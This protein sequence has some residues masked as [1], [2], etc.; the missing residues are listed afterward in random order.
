MAAA[1]AST[2]VSAVSPGGCGIH[3]ISVRTDSGHSGPSLIFVP[4]LCYPGFA[5]AASSCWVRTLA[6]SASRAAFRDG[7]ATEEIAEDSETPDRTAAA[8]RPGI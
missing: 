7:E 4:L 5:L 6:G 8:A 2:E 3:S 1:V